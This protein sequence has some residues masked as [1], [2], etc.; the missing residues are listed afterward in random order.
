MAKISIYPLDGDPKLSDKLIGTSVG[1]SEGGELK[2]PTYNFSLQQ[3]LDLFLP[4][5]PANNLQGILDFG[6]TATQDINLFG[7]ITTTELEVTDIA[8]LFKAYISSELYIQ[9]SLFDTSDSSGTLGQVLTSTEDGVEWVTLPPIFTPNLQQVL[10]IG[11]VADIDIILDAG[12]ESNSLTSNVITSNNEFYIGGILYDWSGSEGVFGQILVSLGDKVEWQDFPLYTA[13]SPLFIDP[14]TKTISIQEANS[15]QNGYLSFT[16]WISFDGKQDA[17]SGTGIVVSSGGTISYITNN[18]ANWNSAYDDT[19]VSASVTGSSTKTLT[20]NQRDGGTVTANWSDPDTGLTSVG[21]TMPSAFS[22]ANSPLISNGVITIT[23]A[24][25]SLQYIKG[26]GTLGTFPILTGYVPYVGA[27]QD[28]DLGI[29]DLTASAFIKSGGTAAQFLKADGSIDNNVYA[30]DSAVVKLTGVQ[31]IAGIKTF[32]ESTKFDYG[33]YL[34]Q[35]GVTA[36]FPGYTTIDGT[37]NGYVVTNGDGRTAFFNLANVTS[38]GYTYPSTSG[39]FALT[40]DLHSPVTI[41]TANGLSLSG[42]QLSLGLASSTLNGALSSTDWNAFNNKQTAGNYIT[43][44]TGEVTASG[45]GAASAT[46]NNASV[47]GKLLTGVNITGGTVL[48]TDSMLTAFG[49]LQNQINS[50]I[51]G[52]I[53]QGVWDANANTPTLTSSVGTDGYYYIVNVAGS[54]NLNGITDW[55]I[56]D[57]AIFHGGTWQKVDNTESVSSVNGQTGAVSLTTD[58][59]SEG[60]TNQYFLNSRARAALSFAAGSGAYNSTTGVITIPT[61]NN[62]ITNGAGYI[63][64]ASLSAVS[65]LSYNS[66][67]GAFSIAQSSGST[68]GFLSSTDWTTFNNKQAQLNGTGFVKISGTTISYDNNTYYLASNPN[69]YIP[70]TALSAGAG[71][72]YNNTTGVI[73]STITQYTDALAR[74]AISL[75][76]T[77]TSGAATYNNTTGVL[78]IPQYAPDLSGFVP[79]TGATANVDLGTHTLLAK[80]LVINHS[81]GSGVAASIT[82]NGSGEA[83]TVIK[84]SGSGNAMSV[85]GGLTSLVNLSLS[86]VANATGD[87]LTHSGSTINKRTPAQVLS[88]IGG[89]AALTNPI[90]GTGTTNYLPKFT[91]ASTLGNSQIFDNGTNV[92][93]GTTSPS[94]AFGSGLDVRSNSGWGEIKVEGIAGA[95]AAVTL[96][97]NGTILGDISADVDKNLS[98]RSDNAERMRIFSSGNVFIGSSPTDAGFKLDVNGTGRFSTSSS[99]N[100]VV[101]RT[102]SNGVFM[103]FLDNSGNSVF[104][105]GNNGDFLVQTPSGGFSN[106]LVISNSGAATFSSSVTTTFLNIG[107]SNGQMGSINS[108]NANGG[109]ITWETSGV[110]IADIGT[111]QQIF[112]AGGNDTFGINARGARN[113]VFGSNNTERMRINSSYVTTS[114]VYESFNAASGIHFGTS[115]SGGSFGF[116]KWDAGGS[117]VYLGNSYNSAFN[118]NLVITSSGNVL[119]NTTTDAG[120]RLDVNGTG[121]FSGNLRSS[122]FIAVNKNGA[123]GVGEGPYFVLSQVV[124]AKQWLFQLNGS[125]GLDYWHYNGSN[126][127]IPLNLASSGAATFSSSVTA[128]ELIRARSFSFGIGGF[129]LANDPTA[130]SRNWVLGNDTVAFGD[131]GIHQSTTQTGSTYTIP[132]YINPSGNV[133]I[134]TTSPQSKLDV[135]TSSF[136]YAASPLKGTGMNLVGSAGSGVGGGDGAASGVLNIIDNAVMGINNGGTITLGGN[137]I[138]SGNAFSLTYAGIKGGKENGTDYNSAGYLALYTTP[139][140]AS[141]AERMRITSGGFVCIGVQSPIGSGTNTSVGATFA[142]TYN[143]LAVTDSNYIQRPN[144]S[145]G[146]FFSFVKGATTVGSITVSGSSTS[147]NTSSDYR[148]KED[149]NPVENALNRLQNL[150]PVNFAWKIDGKRVDGF[151]AH[152]LAEVIPEAVTGKK[153]EIKEDGTPV[154]QGIDQSKIV[155]LLVAAI[156]ELK[157]EI[158]I[159]KNK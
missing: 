122:S 107:S 142:N 82:K 61:N 152:E 143:W 43:S 141:P 40:S 74:A 150:K 2:D 148:L 132:F 124:D 92:G 67:T 104:L 36:S 158:E 57:W 138:S 135:V 129:R 87:F 49:K 118:K 156:Q 30:L 140:G 66:G 137:Y 78:N 127:I 94:F 88:D 56:G 76:T 10:A 114:N 48:A 5:I 100:L 84:G 83:L 147:Y 121:R 131:F 126:W 16:D 157:A 3:L 119:I 14:A 54:T 146:G 65:P 1:Y 91:G 134:G 109:Y 81:S 58:N 47:T 117:Y 133:G 77:G 23:G 95:G 155:P 6:N 113:I 18:S 46:L 149:I 99:T 86:T 71:I 96:Y 25:N 59:I 69:A 22:V 123:N 32:S 110:T 35:D 8:N 151:I 108:S 98:F 75:T 80:D 112:G 51:G 64:L 4:N 38:L 50:L 44:L 154:Y 53:Y 102:G 60:I 79:Y 62:Q 55:K 19:I 26:D 24:G 72:S 13:T 115:G 11:N 33:V 63:T 31:T 97:S 85:T 159:L 45:P 89:Q 90:T 105:G 103:Q 68:N 34:K 37:T 130:A 153:D 116:L 125:Q 139:N 12:I 17:L 144:N 28:V 9:G 73:A 101:Q 106:K 7:K 41:G 136:S 145:D 27:T 128:G 21:V 39:T 42:Q 93:I 20:L 52:S 29:Y 120:F 15:T 70:L 111:S